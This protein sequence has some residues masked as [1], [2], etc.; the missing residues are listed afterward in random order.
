[1]YDFS[2]LQL[3]MSLGSVGL[4]G[5]YLGKIAARQATVFKQ[6]HVAVS[7]PQSSPKSYSDPPPLS[8]QLI[9]SDNFT[10]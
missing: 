3:E 4:A 8:H 9:H 7:P 2:L 10:F 6:P 1:M 5:F